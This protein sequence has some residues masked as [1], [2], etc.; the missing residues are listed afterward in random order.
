MSDEKNKYEEFLEKQFGKFK[1][2]DLSSDESL[3]DALTKV[4]FGQDYITCPLQNKERMGK[5][6]VEIFNGTP[7]EYPGRSHLV[8]DRTYHK[9]RYHKKEPDQEIDPELLKELAFLLFEK[10]G[11]IQK[12]AQNF[13]C[14]DWKNIELNALQHLLK[15]RGY[16]LGDHIGEGWTRDVYEIKFDKGIKGKR[17]LKVPKLQTPEESLTTTI[18]RSK[19]NLEEREIQILESLDHPNIVEIYEAFN[20]GKRTCIIEK[21]FNA[22]SLEDLVKYRATPLGPDEFKFLFSQLFLALEY[23]HLHTEGI[24]HRDIKPSNILINAHGANC[25]RPGSVK[26]TDLQ[27]AEVINSIEDKL[28]PTR[29]G[30]AYT[31]P[32]LLNDFME[33][34]ESKAD[35]STD[36]YA[37]GATMYYT[38]TGEHLFETSLQTDETGIEISI[39]GKP[40]KASL[41]WNGERVN[42][43]DLEE[44]DNYVESKINRKITYPNGCYGHDSQYNQNE[45]RKLMKTLLS[46]KR[47]ECEPVQ[48]HKRIRELFEEALKKE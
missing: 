28:L 14:V 2:I 32:Y 38:L 15:G 43:I 17:V 23:L 1:G 41:N 7:G 12:M 27:N 16:T 13:P 44:H 26:L 8:Y 33:G 39:E 10:N 9:L 21:D 36:F 46:S 5:F 22:E 4:Q 19:G 3:E 29:G 31:A 48:Y 24:L 20:L 37:L 35:F 11:K 47:E 18:N 40:V 42:R 30:T 25:Y 45:L 34:T 6:L